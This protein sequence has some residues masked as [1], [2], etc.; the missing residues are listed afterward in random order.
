MSGSEPAPAD[1]RE[2]RP[3][4]E[5]DAVPGRSGALW[6]VGTVLAVALLTGVSWGLLRAFGG[7]AGEATSREAGAEA[8][9]VPAAARHGP[10]GRGP[11]PTGPDPATRARIGTYR[12]I[13]REAG[14]VAIPVE[15]AMELMVRTGGAVG[16]TGGAGAPPSG[17]GRADGP[18]E[19]SPEPDSE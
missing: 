7:G 9:G 1:G 15:K 10:F 11:V 13:D 2:E 6:V 17:G 18:R 4:Q 16:R 5:P 14:V 12:W 8:G 19:D 3:V